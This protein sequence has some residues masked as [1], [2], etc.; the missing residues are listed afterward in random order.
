MAG[1]LIRAL[2]PAVFLLPHARRAA[3]RT[4]WWPREPG[5]PLTAQCLFALDT[6]GSVLLPG[7]SGNVLVSLT[8]SEAGLAGSEFPGVTSNVTPCL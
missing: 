8:D 6:T 3:G 1:P 5:G 4:E 7:V 2:L